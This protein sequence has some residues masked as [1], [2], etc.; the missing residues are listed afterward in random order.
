MLFRSQKNNGNSIQLF[1]GKYYLVVDE[2]LNQGYYA[3]DNFTV[4]LGHNNLTLDS[5]TNGFECHAVEV[6]Y[7]DG[8]SLSITALKDSDGNTGTYEK[9]DKSTSDTTVTVK[10]YLEKNHEYIFS[11]KSGE[12][13]V[14]VSQKITSSISA[15]DLT[16]PYE[17]VK[18]S[19]YVGVTADGSMT[20]KYT[21]NT[22]DYELGVDIKDGNYEFNVPK[23]VT[24][25]MSVNK[26]TVE[27]I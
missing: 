7:T 10:Y 15:V 21:Y 4:H 14:A 26:I 19:G 11:V 12:D 5:L 18:V 6:K 24:V 17:T 3:D 16:S 1:A 27:K 22:V 9:G 8:D 25:S 13:K 20:V 2:L 23:N